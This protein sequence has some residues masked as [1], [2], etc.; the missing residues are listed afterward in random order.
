MRVLVRVLIVLLAVA[1][2]A[3]QSSSFDIASLGWPVTALP[4][5]VELDG[6]PMTQEWWVTQ[7]FTPHA[8]VVTVDLRT[9]NLCKGPVV[10]A[11]WEWVWQRIS[12]RDELT[13]LR[14]SQF[15][16]WVPPTGPCAP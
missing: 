14:G 7:M 13:R 4:K 2:V 3:A 8:R 11:G 9:G 5:A 16:R 15:D 1:P 10:Q 12:G 6:D